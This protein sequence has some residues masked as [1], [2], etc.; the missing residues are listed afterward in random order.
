MKLNLT[1]KKE[2]L[3]AEGKV[4]KWGIKE[5]VKPN[6]KEEAFTVMLPK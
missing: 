6:T 5:S 1:K 4:S 3:Y 2:K